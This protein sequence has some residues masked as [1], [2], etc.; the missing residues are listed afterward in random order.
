MSFAAPLLLLG[1]LALP[2]LVGAYVRAERRARLGRAAFAA[3]AVI[4]S[5]APQR[6]GWRRHA[7]LVFYAAALAA[8]V[9]AL[10]RPQRTVAVPVEQATVVLATDRS[11]SMAARDVSPSRLVAARR[12]AKRFLDEVP[13][14]VRVGAVA[15]NHGARTLRSPT[16]DRDAIVRALAALRPSGGTATGDAL[17]VA[18]RIAR[19]PARTGAQPPPAAIVLLSDG[20]SVRGSDPVAVAEEAR[21]ANVPVYT[22]ALGTASGTIEVPSSR[23]GTTTRRVPP[24]PQTLR[25]IAQRSGGQAFSAEDAKGLDAVFE[26]LGSQVARERRPRQMT[27]AVA[28]GALGLLAIGAAL[29]LRWF[30]RLPV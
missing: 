29:S 24:D 3:P 9:V 30:G 16:R 26:R 19:T 5:V 7:P 2:A 21:R 8:L 14:E 27:A 6:P 4:A 11:G 15:F 23:G 1:L 17:E 28:G 25:R 22:V 12:A 20:K 10:A 18:L 13:G